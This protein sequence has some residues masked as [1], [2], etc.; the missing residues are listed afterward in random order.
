MAKLKLALDELQVETFETAADAGPHGTVRALSGNTDDA[1]CWAGTWGG[2]NC[3]STGQ[4]IMCGCTAGGQN[5]GTCD[6]SSGGTCDGYN[7]T[8]Q[9]TCPNYPTGEAYQSCGPCW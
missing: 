1:Y 5:N 4:Q 8:C 7:D 3:E 2:T 9:N 6:L